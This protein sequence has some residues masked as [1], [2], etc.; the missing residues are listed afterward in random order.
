MYEIE[1]TS[2]HIFVRA[3]Q[4][5]NKDILVRKVE[6]GNLNK[7]YIETDSLTLDDI[8]K[9][10]HLTNKIIEEGREIKEYI[11]DTLDIAKRKFPDLRSYDERIEGKVRVIEI[12][13]Y[14]HA[15]CIKDHANNSKACELFIITHLSREG[16]IYKIEFVAGLDA[17][18]QA[19]DFGIKCLRISNELNVSMNTLESTI[20][21]MKRDLERYKDYVREYNEKVID[22]AEAEKIGNVSL[23]DLRLD[24]FDDKIIFKK[25]NELIKKDG[26]IVLLINK[27]DD[28]SNIILACSNNI[29]IDC[30]M[31]LDELK[32]Y[33]YK[34]GG[35]PKFASGA[36]PI[37]EIEHINDVKTQIYKRYKC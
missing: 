7:I 19:L 23:Y 28:V 26:I 17:K 18:L 30:R 24:K 4:N 27:K 16:N 31:M 13:G 15:A 9:A 20:R 1:H 14:D 8:Y 25:V 6:H 29:E 22:K 37:N 11:F 10:E 35:K 2:E 36:L 5:L 32:I 33:G 34:G 3:L 21:N 12:D